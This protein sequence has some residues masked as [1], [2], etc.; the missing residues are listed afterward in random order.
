[1]TSSTTSASELRRDLLAQLPAAT[2]DAV[3]RIVA[4]AGSCAVYAVAGAVRDTLLDRAMVDLDLVMECDAPIVVRAALPAAN[5]TVHAR[6]RTV[7][8]TVGGMRIDAATARCETFGR[9]GA[10][11]RI[12]PTTSDLDLRRRDFAMNAIAIRLSGN[13]A[14]LDPCG[15]IDDIAARRIRVLHDASF[16]DDATRIFRALRYA[17]RLGF[18]LDTQTQHLMTR[19]VRYVDVIG[20]ERLRREIELMLGEQTGGSALESAD[21]AGALRVVH[22]ALSW[23]GERTGAL[24]DRASLRLPAHP[25]GFA[26]LAAQASPDEAHSIVARLKLKRDEGAAVLLEGAEVPS[27]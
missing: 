18:S 20:G 17:A 14:L 5:V 19:D 2:R 24:G 4:T 15:G 8:I 11:P 10:L 27:S 9:P 1:M 23:D 22:P 25:Y 7:S 26:L 21:G 12:A 16:Q 6:F 3:A 13:A